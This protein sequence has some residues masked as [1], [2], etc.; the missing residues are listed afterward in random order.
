MSGET[1]NTH[2]GL[3]LEEGVWPARLQPLPKTPKTK[4]KKKKIKVS[5]FP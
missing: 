3:L 4:I 5:F 2:Q 1:L